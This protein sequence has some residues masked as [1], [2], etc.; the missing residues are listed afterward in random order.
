[1]WVNHIDAR[2]NAQYA[3]ILAAKT[4]ELKNR[5]VKYSSQL[6]I[7][8]SQAHELLL[9]MGFITNPKDIIAVRNKGTQAILEVLR[10]IEKISR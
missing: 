8:Q 4:L 9:E 2:I 6:Y 5:G 3:C 1:M 10:H 7:L